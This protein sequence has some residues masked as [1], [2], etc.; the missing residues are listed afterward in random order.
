MI[1]FVEHEL[2]ISIALIFLFAILFSYRYILKKYGIVS[3]ADIKKREEAEKKLKESESKFRTIF[4]NS[5]VA[6]TLTN[7]EEQIISWNKYTEKIL[8][9]KPSDLHMK[10]VSS[11]YP[12]EEWQRIRS[13]NIR[14]AGSRQHLETVMIRKDGSLVNVEISIS[15]LKDSQG[16]V[17]GSI[18][19]MNDITDRKKTEAK[20]KESEK[21]FRTIFDNSAAAITLTDDKE[22]IISWNFYAERLLGRS[23]QDLYLK[24]VSSIYEESEWKRI[25]SLGLREKGPEHHFESK[26]VKKDGSLIDAEVSVT[27]LSDDKGQITGSLGIIN[28]ITKRKRVEKELQEANED[29]IANERAVRSLY[30]DLK[31]T[32][33]E[34]LEKQEQLVREHQEQIRLKEKAETATR[35][36]SDFL[37]NMSHEI[38]TPLNSMIGFSQLLQK[39]VIDEKPRKFIDIIESSSQHLLTIVNDILDFEKAIAGRI[40]LESMPVNLRVLIKNVFHLFEGHVQ[41][42]PIKMSFD[43]DRK[44]PKELFADEVRLKQ[45]LINLLSNALKFT[46][47]GFVIL[48][49]GIESVSESGHAKIYSL[50]FDVSDSGIGIAENNLKKIFEQFTQAETS[51]TRQYGGTGLGLSICQAYV[52][53]MG[54]RIWVT[55]TEGKGSSFLFSVSMPDCILED[56]RRKD[57][58]KQDPI[59]FSG[60]RILI[61][62]DN[63]PRREK[64]QRFFTEMKCSFD[65]VEDGVGFIAN[66]Q[67]KEY[68]ACFVNVQLP[69]LSGVMAAKR[70]RVKK[71]KDLPI[72]AI[73][74]ATFFEDKKNCQE[75]G[76]DDFITTPLSFNEISEKLRL[77]TRNKS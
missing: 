58:E 6:I 8:G 32:Q 4:E 37:S 77:V 43:V 20:L 67:E 63:L 41:D 70:N 13:L 21:R 19:V 74:T 28:D 36:K 46:K 53:L 61:G 62:E 5:A 40:V 9:M 68:D 59:D 73:A 29:L 55:A 25:R 10:P 34:L 65:I 38:R 64:L 50:R 31:K 47:K 66:I 48:K 17:V 14:K 56:V 71:D 27:I 2:W 1:K 30:E 22:R 57:T 16:N 39:I 18:G 54:G 60:T 52:E 26:M 3:F 23:H 11:F 42:R 72:I 76:M 45:I 75:A 35:A 15:V 49:V 44:V 12:R 33:K 69:K 24:P 51:T 7:K